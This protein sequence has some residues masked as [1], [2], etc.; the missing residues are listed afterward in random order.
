VGSHARNQ[1]LKLYFQGRE[2]NKF[3]GKTVAFAIC[4]KNYLTQAR[5]KNV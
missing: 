4:Y 3:G 5:Q 1:N 2:K